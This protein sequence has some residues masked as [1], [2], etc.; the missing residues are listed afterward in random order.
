MTTIY[1]IH[2]YKGG[3]GVT[4]TACAVAYESARQGHGTL[5]IDTTGTHDTFAW[6][7]MATGDENYDYTRLPDYPLTMICV[8]EKHG[9]LR[10]VLTKDAHDYDVIVIDAGSQ[11]PSETYGEHHVIPVCVVR[12]DYLTLRRTVNVFEPT[13]DILVALLHSEAAL[14]ERDIASVLRQNPISSDLNPSVQRAIDAGLPVVRGHLFTWASK[15]LEITPAV[16][17]EV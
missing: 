3:V 12:N 2:S 10:S 13:K 9:H 17:P 15:V 4:T 11:G 1:N 5:L 8:D 16:W 14:T 6:S 7:G